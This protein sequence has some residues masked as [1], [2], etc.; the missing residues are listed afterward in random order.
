MTQLTLINRV[1]NAAGAAWNAFRGNVGASPPTATEMWQPGASPRR[2]FD[3]LMSYYQN[4]GIY[5]ESMMMLRAMGITHEP[6]K[7]LRNPAYRAVEFYAM[8]IWPGSL[9]TA[10]P[11]KSENDLIAEPIRQLW[12]WS[13]WGLNKQVLAR[14]CATYGSM[15]IKVA[16]R[17]DGRPYLDLINP[18]QVV[19]FTE[20][21]RGFITRIRVDTLQAEGTGAGMRKRTRSEIWDKAAGTLTIV[22]HDRGDAPTDQLPTSGQGYEV[23]QLSEFQIDFVPFVHVRLRSVGGKWGL[24]A[25]VPALEKIDEANRITT[26]LHQQLFKNKANWAVNAGGND[27]S[28]RPLAPPKLTTGSVSTVTGDGDVITVGDEVIFRLPGN[29]Q[30]QSLVPQLQYGPFLTAINDQMTEIESDLPELAYYR[31]RQ[32]NTN[33]GRHART[34]LTDSIARAVE[35]RGNLETALIQA[36]QMALTIGTNAGIWSGLG[37]FAGGDFEHSFAE[38]DV[39]PLDEIDRLEIAMKKQEAGVG[40]RQSLRDMNYTNAQIDDWRAE[41]GVDEAAVNDAA[42]TLLTRRG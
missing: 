19:E 11:I 6:M 21:E 22:V 39:I 26:R 35:A 40:K 9:P 3:A 5:T 23:T 16:Q 42:R 25:F 28:G 32:L 27:A 2:Y 10:L 31:L 30:M 24:S 17:D 29:S 15:F 8:T 4:N 13:N 14:N 34:L 33:S 37:D 36:Q 20:D 7:A 41:D 12:S 1:T 38:R 18:Q